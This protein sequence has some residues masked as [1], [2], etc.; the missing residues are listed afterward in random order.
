MSNR[1][2]ETPER[3][4]DKFRAMELA[5]DCARNE[6][7][8]IHTV[9][10]LLAAAGKIYAATCT[11]EVLSEED[12]KDRK[13]STLTLAEKMK[14]A[15]ELSIDQLLQSSNDLRE[16]VTHLLS[17][18]EGSAGRWD[19]IRRYSAEASHMRE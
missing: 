12:E 3:K 19:T 13:N 7:G 15:S 18:G 14:A 10:D 16:G 4:A 8:E 9:N 11:R 2:E 17:K 6:I 1:I 5:L